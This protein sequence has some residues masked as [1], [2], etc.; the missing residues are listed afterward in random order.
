MNNSFISFEI[1]GKVYFEFEE[2]RFIKK[3]LNFNDPFRKY[4]GFCWNVYQSLDPEFMQNKLV[5]EIDKKSCVSYAV[6][7]FVCRALKNEL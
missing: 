4:C 3:Y 2:L 7:K 5:I 1:P 6:H